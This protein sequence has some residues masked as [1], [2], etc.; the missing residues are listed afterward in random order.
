MFVIVISIEVTPY[1]KCFI[2]QEYV[3]ASIKLKPLN[4]KIWKWKFNNVNQEKATNF[5]ELVT[6]KSDQ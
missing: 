5:L 2:I 1:L 3:K 4:S 6:G